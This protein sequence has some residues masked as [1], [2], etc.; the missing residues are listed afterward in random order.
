MYNILHLFFRLVYAKWRDMFAEGFIGFLKFN[1]KR[2]ICISMSLRC[3]SQSLVYAQ[4]CR[5][6][7]NQKKKKKEFNLQPMAVYFVVLE[8]LTAISL[9]G[10]LK[11]YLQEKN[12]FRKEI[13]M[14]Y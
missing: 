2:F 7:E 5:I 1:L 3:L 8:L 13:A 10:C 9:F 4:G 12:L 6:N 14:V 11:R